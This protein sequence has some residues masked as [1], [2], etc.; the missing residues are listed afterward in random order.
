M[1]D[2][3]VGGA[4]AERHPGSSPAPSTNSKLIRDQ[5][6]PRRDPKKEKNRPPFRYRATIPYSMPRDPKRDD[7]PTSGQSSKKGDGR[8]VC[9]VCGQVMNTTSS[10]TGEPPIYS[11]CT[12]CKGLPHR[13]PGSTAS[14]N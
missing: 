3:Y 8:T 6:F 1:A 14:L 7:R 12:S 10:A 4:Y 9:A 11:I 13:N 5:A 2:T